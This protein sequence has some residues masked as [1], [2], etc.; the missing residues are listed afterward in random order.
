[1]SKSIRT[2][3]HKAIQH[4]A[5]GGEVNEVVGD[6]S[7]NWIKGRGRS[8]ADSCQGRKYSDQIDW[9]EVNKPFDPRH[10]DNAISFYFR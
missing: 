5:N 6:N 7:F 10:F 4:V 9:G 3:Q 2:I 8:P 1:M